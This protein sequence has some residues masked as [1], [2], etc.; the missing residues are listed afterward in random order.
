MATKTNTTPATKRVVITLEI[1]EPKKGMRALVISGA[2]AGEMPLI[3][4]GTFAERHALLD[5][6]WADLLRR[7]DQ[8]PTVTEPKAAKP[9]AGKADVKES[10]EVESETT[11]DNGESTEFADVMDKASTETVEE[12]A[13]EQGDQLVVPVGVAPADLPV[14][15]G[16]STA[17]TGALEAAIIASKENHE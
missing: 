2:P 5:Q 7:P 15:E 17:P 14:I 12:T 4:A 13:P 16:D 6:M 8:T 10:D 3:K 11:D 1:G 9:A